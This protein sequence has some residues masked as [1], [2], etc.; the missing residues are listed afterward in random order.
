MSVTAIYAAL[1]ALFLV[2][3]SY[4]V[5]RLRWSERIGLGDGRNR[6]LQ[7]AMRV[8]ANFTEYVPLALILM[9][10]AEMQGVPIW[11]IHLLGLTVLAGRM[12]HA[13]GFGREPERLR[14]R[15]F[16]MVL[17]FSALIAAAT[18]NLAAAVLA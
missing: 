7:R 8:H 2:V 3:L 6:T 1:A 5:I 11:V 16:G 9:A 15:V 14:L 17:T 13:L 4:R 12:I 18:A 10:L